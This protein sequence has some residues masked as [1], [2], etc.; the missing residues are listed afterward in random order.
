MKKYTGVI[1]IVMIASLISGC[2]HQLEIKN[3]SSYR[4]TSLNSLEKQTR[5]GIIADSNEMEGRRLAKEIAESLQKYNVWTTTSAIIDK[6]SLDY[7]A[8]IT[9]DSNYKGS[10][11][12]FL[13]NW[14]GFL[15]FT[16]A[17]HGYNYNIE[18][19][20]SVLISNAESGAKIDSIFTPIDL[21]I[22][23][24]AINRTWTEIGWL[25][26]GIIPLIGGVFFIQYDNSVTPIAHEKAI[27]VISDF[28]AQ[29]IVEKLKAQN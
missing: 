5:V 13:I 18:H 14:P 6:E 22:R 15:I 7:I 8:T 28:I 29:E 19:N 12:N 9:I 2:A 4:S 24:A 1:F 3:L 17:W 16:P 25:E 10:G 21:D 11:W 23:H 26:V 20:V 27:P